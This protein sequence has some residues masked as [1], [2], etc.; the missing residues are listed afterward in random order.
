MENRFFYIFAAINMLLFNPHSTHSGV[1]LIEVLQQVTTTHQT[2]YLNNLN[3]VN[4][5]NEGHFGFLSE[6]AFSYY[7]NH[8]NQ[9]R[10]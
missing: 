9:I 1:A 6:M 5:E 8:I 4:Y 7:T 2:E 10:I 3:S